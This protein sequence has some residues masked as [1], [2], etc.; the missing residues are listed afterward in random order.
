MQDHNLYVFANSSIIKYSLNENGLEPEKAEVWSLRADSSKL[1]G[2]VIDASIKIASESGPDGL[3]LIL[4]TTQGQQTNGLFVFLRKKFRTSTCDLFRTG[5]IFK[6]DLVKRSLI[7][8]NVSNSFN[9]DFQDLHVDESGVCVITF[10]DSTSAKIWKFPRTVLKA[11]GSKC[12]NVCTC[13]NGICDDGR[14]GTGHC[15]NCTRHNA[16]ETI[17]NRVK[18]T[19]VNHILAYVHA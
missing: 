19:G 13:V 15:I 11:W 18:Q 6:H 5:G 12:D 3:W 14:T 9:D 2:T 16:L 1:S 4:T 17:A 7:G 8:Y 10:G